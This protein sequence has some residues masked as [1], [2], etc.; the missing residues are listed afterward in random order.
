MRQNPFSPAKNL[1]LQH[2][3]LK[4]RDKPKNFYDSL[5]RWNFL[6]GKTKGKVETKERGVKLQKEKK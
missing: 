5:F 6:K 1:Y 2:G 4:L 3:N